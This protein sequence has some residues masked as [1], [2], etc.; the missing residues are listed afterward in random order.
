M[1]PR[2]TQMMGTSS[3]EWVR[4][5]GTSQLNPSRNPEIQILDG[6]GRIDH[7]TL[8]ADLCAVSDAVLPRLVLCTRASI[9]RSTRP[10]YIRI[11]VNI[12]SSS[13]LFLPLN[14]PPTTKRLPPPSPSNT[15]MPRQQ[16][17]LFH[18]I[19]HLQ[20]RNPLLLPLIHPP[21]PY[22]INISS[23]LPPLKPLL[24]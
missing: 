10:E 3:T 12:Q 19:Q 16:P 18:L 21:L 5:A 23:C 6:L 14:I 22:K 24:A 7:Q 13:A 1:V 15:I 4:L 2:G 11:S 9:L 20:A 17:P 8:N